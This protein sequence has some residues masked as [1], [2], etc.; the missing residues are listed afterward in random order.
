MRLYV[1]AYQ[2]D[3]LC[4]LYRMSRC[5]LPF[6]LYTVSSGEFDLFSV[7]S[8]SMIS[9]NSLGMVSAVPSV[10]EADALGG[11]A[12]FDHFNQF[13]NVWHALTI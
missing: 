13:V 3:C 8:S 6:Q 2:Y 11:L 5:D 1:C 10:V 9:D 4:V 12:F 7:F